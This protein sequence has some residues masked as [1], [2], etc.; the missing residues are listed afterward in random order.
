MVCH[1][2]PSFRKTRFNVSADDVMMLGFLTSHTRAHRAVSH[3]FYYTI[4]IVYIY[5][6][7]YKK[8]IYRNMQL[9]NVQRTLISVYSGC[10]SGEQTREYMSGSS[11]WCS[12]VLSPLLT[13]FV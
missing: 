9:T 11:C 7:I 2:K 12:Q 10:K 8:V 1:R 5:I 3:L 4:Q 6:Y 13:A